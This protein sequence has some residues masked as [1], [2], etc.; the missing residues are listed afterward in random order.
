MCAIAGALLRDVMSP[1]QIDQAN[2]IL[3]FIL[4]R[5]GERGRDGRGINITSKNQ[6]SV[7]S[8][9][10]KSIKQMD[11]PRFDH[12]EML[13]GAPTKH[14]N[15]ISNFRAEPTTEFVKNKCELDQQPYNLGGLPWRIVH[16]G[17]IANDK[18]LR[19]SSYPSSIDSAAILELLN[20]TKQDPCLERGSDLVLSEFAHSIGRL[21]GSYAILAS[22]KDR[23]QDMF[24][25][26]NYMPIWYIRTELGFFFASSAEYFPVHAF[27]KMIA[28][29]TISKFR[30]DGTHLSFPI[31][32]RNPHRKK[33]ALVIC[34]GGLDSVVAATY[35]QKRLG[36]DVTLCHFTYGSRAQGPEVKAINTIAL[37]LEVPVVMFPMD[38]YDKEDLHEVNL[39]LTLS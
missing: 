15:I 7:T 35:A 16:N 26:T 30:N 17:T 23:P 5:S 22:Y 18:E 11:F 28:P 13:I 38:I 14:L 37:E 19:D 2:D 36:M 27:P 34:S 31:V 32:P 4:V 8:H 29:Y 9:T 33:K 6:S 10:D 25:A 21:K 1:E 12:Q 3:D 39:K 24:V 20:R